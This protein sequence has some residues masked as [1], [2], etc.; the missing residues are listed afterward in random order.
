MTTS[1]VGRREIPR[2]VNRASIVMGLYAT[3]SVLWTVAYLLFSWE[4]AALIEP[5]AVLLCTLTYY[6]RRGRQWARV[7][8]WVFFG[9]TAATNAVSLTGLLFTIFVVQLVATLGSFVLSCAVCLWLAA[10]DSNEF[11]AAKGLITRRYEPAPALRGSTV[12]RPMS[13][14]PPSGPG[15]YPAPD[16]PNDQLYWDG[17]G[18]TARRRWTAAGY[19]E[20]GAVHPEPRPAARQ[21]VTIAPDARSHARTAILLVALAVIPPAIAIVT[22]RTTGHVYYGPLQLQ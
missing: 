12:V 22:L 8:S 14:P 17:T 18:W 15:W 9:L 13:A 3:V 21:T 1:V 11:F 19:E 4:L 6:V 2:P 10:P 16:L 5:T 7:V 20:V